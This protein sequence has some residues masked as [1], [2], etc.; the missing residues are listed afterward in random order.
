MIVHTEGNTFHK[1]TVWYVQELQGDMWVDSL[2]GYS[3]LARAKAAALTLKEHSQK[4][5]RIVQISEVW[6]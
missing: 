1:D 3:T 5:I 4:T 2:H 6:L